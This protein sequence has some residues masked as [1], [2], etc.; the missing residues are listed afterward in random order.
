[1]EKDQLI[2]QLKGNWSRVMVTTQ[3]DRTLFERLYDCFENIGELET[4]LTEG[5]MITALKSGANEMRRI[6]DQILNNNNFLTW[7]SQ[8]KEYSPIEN[9]TRKN[10]EVVI[11]DEKDFNKIIDAIYT[12]RNNLRHGKKEYSPR[13]KKIIR[14]M[15][16]IL[17][18]I[19]GGARLKYL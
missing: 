10:K 6:F 3:D 9:N 13:S 14:T 18:K 15:D 8:L 4:S 12:V 17:Y 11:T 19:V 7:L 16:N 5:K 2:I 1:M